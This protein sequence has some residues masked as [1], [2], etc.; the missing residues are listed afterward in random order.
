MSFDD[1]LKKLNKTLMNPKR[2]LI[3]T[4]LYTFGPKSMAE[5]QKAVGITWGDLSTHVR[6]LEEEGYIETKKVI[7]RRRNKIYLFLTEKGIR[8]YSQLVNILK[9]L[10][11]KVPK[12]PEKRIKEDYILIINRRRKRIEGI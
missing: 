12:E 11:E 6:K 10:I 3:V 9:M 7:T 8:E 4:F 2:F 5:V 1:I